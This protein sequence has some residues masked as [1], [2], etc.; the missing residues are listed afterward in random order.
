MKDWK[1]M[2]DNTTFKDFE[3]RNQTIITQYIGSDKIV[4]IPEGI[5]AIDNFTFT[6]NNEIEEVILPDTVLS[7]GCSAFKGCTNFK[8]NKFAFN[9]HYTR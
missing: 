8:K 5:T 1:T 6:N 7:I 3:V 4:K 9:L 2:R